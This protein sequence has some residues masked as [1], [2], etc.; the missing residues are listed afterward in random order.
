MYYQI[1]ERLAGRRI[2]HAENLQ[3]KKQ[4]WRFSE[5]S[6]I[7]VEDDVYRAYTEMKASD[8]NQS[9]IDRMLEW[10]DAVRGDIRT[11]M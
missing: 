11:E 9:A 3:R 1:A 5:R 4:L 10:S 2:T 6:Q 8:G 7:Q